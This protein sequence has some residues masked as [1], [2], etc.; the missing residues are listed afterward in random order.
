MKVPANLK[1]NIHFQGL[2]DFLKIKNLLRVR[3]LSKYEN[4]EK[5]KIL[6]IFTHPEICTVSAKKL[7]QAKKI[8]LQESS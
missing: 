2:Y 7:C 1:K 5:S 8:S 4:I 3:G 6:Y